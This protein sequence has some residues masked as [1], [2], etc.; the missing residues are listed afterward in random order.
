MSGKRGPPPLLHKCAGSLYV[1]PF[2][3]ETGSVWD[4]LLLAVPCLSIQ[5]LCDCRLLGERRGGREGGREGKEQRTPFGVTGACCV[6]SF[7]S[8]ISEGLFALLE[9]AG[10]RVG[11]RL[12]TAPKATVLY[13]AP[14]WNVG[15]FSSQTAR[16]V[17]VPVRGM[18]PGFW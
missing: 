12:T 13:H 7:C 1:G 16:G 11:L 2:G 8:G 5:W 9:A 4:W 6:P 14:H 10:S 15:Q 17:G 3:L 18:D